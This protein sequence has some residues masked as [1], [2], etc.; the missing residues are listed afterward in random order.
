[1]DKQMLA[2]W[3]TALKS[4]GYPF[5]VHA[6]RQN[7]CYCA[8]G[9]LL[10]INGVP[11]DYREQA[12]FLGNSGLYGHNDMESKDTPWHNVTKL[13]DTATS[14]KPVIEYLEGLLA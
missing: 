5:G 13:N 14:F 9:V 1:M 10:E 3:I 11:W 4:G 2:N 6:Y 12:Q 8:V 7:G